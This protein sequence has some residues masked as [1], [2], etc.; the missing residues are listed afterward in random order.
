MSGGIPALQLT[1]DDACKFLAAGTHL[2]TTNCDFQ[3]ESYVYKR[4]SDGKFSNI[5]S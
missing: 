5:S 1:E 4:R 2:G 3:M